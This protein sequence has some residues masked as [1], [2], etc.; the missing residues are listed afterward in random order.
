MMAPHHIRDE[1]DRGALRALWFGALALLIVASASGCVP[2]LRP[3]PETSYDRT[4]SVDDDCVAV[5]RKDT[6]NDCDCP[7]DAINQADV[8]RFNAEQA[9]DCPFGPDVQCDCVAFDAVCSN[10]TCGA[11][12]NDG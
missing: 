1:R 11:V 10:G 6:C 3:N 7:N 4:C 2:D 5:G 12:P 9:L 8:E